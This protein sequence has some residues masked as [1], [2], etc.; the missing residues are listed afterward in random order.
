MIGQL[1]MGGSVGI[2]GGSSGGQSVGSNLS[3]GVL[4]PHQTG[5]QLVHKPLGEPRPV[6]LNNSKVG[7]YQNSTKVVA[8]GGLRGSSTGSAKDN[9]HLYKMIFPQNKRPQKNIASSYLRGI[10]SQMSGG[11]SQGMN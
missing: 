1:R 2:T 6:K 8:A 4:Q 11:G 5:Y 3:A 9:Q 7:T 10:E